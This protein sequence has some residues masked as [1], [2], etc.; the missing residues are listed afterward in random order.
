MKIIIRNKPEE[1]SK[2]VLF[3]L[4]LSFFGIISRFQKEEK[5][6]KDSDSKEKTYERIVVLDPAAVEMI[7]LLGSEDKI[8]GIAKL[9][10]SEIWPEDKTGKL[11]SVGTFI[12]P[13]LEK[14]ISL[15]PDMV[16]GSF[17]TTETMDKSLKSNGI[18]IMKIRASSIEEIFENFQELGKI[19]GKEEMVNKIIAEKKVKIEE[20]KRMETKEKKG[21]FILSATPMRVFGKN[22]LP[23]D[24]MKMLNIKNIAE[25]LGSESPTLTPEYIIKENPDIILTF[26]RDPHE[27]VKG[28]PQIKGINALK[29][30]KFITLETNH[31]LRGSP[32][33][34]DYII[35]VYQKVKEKENK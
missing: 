27:I 11:E 35:D 3:I 28:N 18:E 13:S 15:K 1:L 30:N 29:N 5:G 31:V 8:V 9:E 25:D 2:Y 21:V 24:I 33:T 23:N 20:I 10:K 6:M 34:I 16:I 19:L 7:Y 17:H 12:R 14:I 32:R 22:T 4:I 26:V